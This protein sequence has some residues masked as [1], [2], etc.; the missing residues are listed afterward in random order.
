MAPQLKHILTTEE[1]PAPSRVQQNA[2][3]RRKGYHGTTVE[4]HIDDR[5]DACP[6]RV[7]QRTKRPK[8]KRI[9]SDRVNIVIK[10]AQ[11]KQKNQVEKERTIK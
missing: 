5:R 3:R 10:L 8:K 7:Q 11:T 6:S 4:A 9:P 1:M 2:K